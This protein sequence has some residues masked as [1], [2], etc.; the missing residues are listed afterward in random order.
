ME[1]RRISSLKFCPTFEIVIMEMESSEDTTVVVI[2]GGPP[3]VHITDEEKLDPLAGNTV[4]NI[5]LQGECWQVHIRAVEEF[6][7]P[8]EEE[9]EEYV[10]SKNLDDFF[11]FRKNHFDLLLVSAV[12]FFWLSSSFAL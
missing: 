2:I 10:S 8:E 1:L 5:L 4:E 3:G 6:S 9:E 7:E 11:V 12:R